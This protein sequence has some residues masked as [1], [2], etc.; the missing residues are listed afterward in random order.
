MQAAARHEQFNACVPPTAQLSRQQTHEMARQAGVSG[1]LSDA[2]RKKE[3]LA[4]S[5]LIIQK[6][7]PKILFHCHQSV[8][9][10]PAGKTGSKQAREA[11]ITTKNEKNRKALGI[12]GLRVPFDDRSPDLRWQAPRTADGLADRIRSIIQASRACF[13]LFCFS[14]S[15]SLSVY[16][17]N[18]PAYIKI[19]YIHI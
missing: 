3:E 2:R 12:L 8:P 19:T 16:C 4:T 6:A 1:K 9:S 11:L 13:F 18:T 7:V 5:F 10:M 15:L 14:L 17:M